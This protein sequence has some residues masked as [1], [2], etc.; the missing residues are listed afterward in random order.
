MRQFLAI[1]N[2]EIKKTLRNR[3]ELFS[4]L[5]MGLIFLLIFGVLG[6][7]L[8]DLSKYDILIPGAIATTAFMGSLMGAITV[9]NDIAEG[10]M[11]EMIIA[12]VARWKIALGKI[13]GAMFIT[14]LNVIFVYFVGM[15][16]GTQYPV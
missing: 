10:T 9:I 5:A 13:L 4:G 7:D 11:K 3:L 15:L 8:G 14:F 12:P 16:F 6:Q 2:R 1:T